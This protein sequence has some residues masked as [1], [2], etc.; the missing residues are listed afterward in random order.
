MHLEIQVAL[1]FLISN[2]YNKLPRR[3]VNIFGEEL[4]KALKQ[5]FAN[6]WYVEK[7]MKGSAFRCLKTGQ[8]TDPVLV[9]A[10]F[11]ANV[12]IADI[13]E[14]LPGEMAIWIDPGEVSY[15][16][17][18]GPVKI[19]WSES[20]MDDLDREVTQFNPEAQIFQ[21]IESPSLSPFAANFAA[22]AAAPQTPQM[23]TTAAFAQTKFGST[24][25]KS[26]SKRTH[27]MS[28]TEFSNYIKQRALAQQAAQTARPRS[29]SPS[30]PAPLPPWESTVWSNPDEPRNF[31]LVA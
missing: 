30:A 2:L 7:P 31:L 3:R 28:P 23:M 10:A 15:R 4:E 12:P 8:P 11:S 5:K 20:E 26:C 19:L 21:P 16:I 18:Q 24:K 9:A 22:K 1:N 29:L 14:N 27:R 25:L 6:H 17:G 13:I